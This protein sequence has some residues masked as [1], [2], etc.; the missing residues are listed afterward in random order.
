MPSVSRSIASS[1]AGRWSGRVAVT[2]TA[3]R[4]GR[5]NSL[6]RP[7]YAGGARCSRGFAAERAF[8][9]REGWFRED[10]GGCRNGAVLT[11]PTA[12]PLFPAQERAPEEEVQAMRSEGAGKTPEGNSV[13]R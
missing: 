12:L 13:A 6:R 1:V 7:G 5:V 2:G 9:G 10:G 3:L 4:S 8:P 11:V